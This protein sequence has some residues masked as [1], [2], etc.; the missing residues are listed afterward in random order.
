MH[1][2]TLIQYLLPQ[3]LLS[4]LIGKLAKNECIWLKNFL[5]NCFIKCYKIKVNEAAET[6]L[7]KYLNF[8]SFFTRA[9]K[10]EARPI[11]PN[12]N[13]IIAPA[14]SQISQ[15]GRITDGK[16]IQAKGFIFSLADLLGSNLKNYTDQLAQGNFITLYL[17]PQDYHRVHMPY[18]GKLL[19]MAHIPGKLF[20]VNNHAAENIPQLF[21]RNER[22]A[23]I[24]ETKFGPMAIVL[25]GAMLVASIEMAWTKDTVFSTKTLNFWDYSDKSMLFNRGDEIGRFQFGSTVILALPRDAANWIKNLTINTKLKMGEKIASIKDQ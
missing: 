18:A 3:H 20:S 25:V 7:N 10:P 8:N 12:E 16:I 4:R 15:F 1:I 2:K 6:D 24:F 19:A 21:A 13:S 11:D 17:S 22:V 9:L 23:A 14:D 5:I